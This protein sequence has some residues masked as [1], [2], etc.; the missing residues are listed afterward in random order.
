VINKWGLNI[1]Y[2]DILEAVANVWIDSK[3]KFNFECFCSFKQEIGIYIFS[4]SF[5][6]FMFFDL[7]LKRDKVWSMDAG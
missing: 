2:N 3:Y 4:R 5:F 1:I 7:R 6:F